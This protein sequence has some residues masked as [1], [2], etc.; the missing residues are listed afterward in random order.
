MNAAFNA[1]LKACTKLIDAAGLFGLTSGKEEE[2]LVADFL[3]PSG[4]T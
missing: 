1:G 4:S 2:C 3:K